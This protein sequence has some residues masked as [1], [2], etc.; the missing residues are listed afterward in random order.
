M[1]FASDCYK[2][3]NQIPKGRVTTYKIIAEKLG[4]KSYRAVGQIVAKNPNIPSTP[5]HRVVKTDGSIGGYALGVDKKIAILE[6]E[7]VEV[8]DGKIVNFEKIIYKF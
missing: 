4:K 6:K 2:L 1:T 7:G 5:C 3:L 8:A